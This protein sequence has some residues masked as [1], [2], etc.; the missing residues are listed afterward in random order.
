MSDNLTRA[1]FAERSIQIF[2]GMTSVD[3][4]EDAIGDLIANLGH[5]AQLQGLNYPHL[6]KTGIG[7][8]HLE[9]IDEDSIDVLPDVIITIDRKPLQ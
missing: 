2:V 5:Y 7:H 6:L 3:T 9:Q 4:L 8:W 1:R